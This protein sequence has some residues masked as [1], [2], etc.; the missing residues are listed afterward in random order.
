M[1]KLKINITGASGTGKTTLARMIADFLQR[2][3]ITVNCLKPEERSAIMELLPARKNLIF[4][5]GK[6]AP[7][8]TSLHPTIL[9]LLQ[10]NE[11]EISTSNVT[12]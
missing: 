1:S 7:V 12:E 3:G 5:K 4:T 11:I 9:D 8:V 2:Q 10:R 6:D